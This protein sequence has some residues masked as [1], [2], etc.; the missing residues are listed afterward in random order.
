M[1]CERKTDEMWCDFDDG[2][3][4]FSFNEIG[5]V[6]ETFGRAQLRRRRRRLRL[7]LSSFVAGC[8]SRAF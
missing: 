1:R 8:C 2:E 4:K 7:T 6:D 5:D 3:N